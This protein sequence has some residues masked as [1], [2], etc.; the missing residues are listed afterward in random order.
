MKA[1]D[2]I[3]IIYA[4][5]K[6]YKT[7]IRVETHDIGD[8]HTIIVIRMSDKTY[9]M[10]IR[11]SKNKQL[12]YVFY[13]YEGSNNELKTTVDKEEY[14]NITLALMQLKNKINKEIEKDFSNLAN[15]I[16]NY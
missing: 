8:D 11:Y 6:N 9:W 13:G 12:A 15:K 1:Y 3:N 10:R 4:L 7:G 5:D 14:L 2:I 16:T